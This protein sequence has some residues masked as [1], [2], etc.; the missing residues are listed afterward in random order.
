MYSNIVHLCLSHGGVYQTHCTCNNVLIGVDI[1]KIE[2]ARITELSVYYLIYVFLGC[3]FKG[4]LRFSAP[5]WIRVLGKI[6][7]SLLNKAVEGAYC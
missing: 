3:S 2:L 7:N 4:N 6:Q 1:N 5:C